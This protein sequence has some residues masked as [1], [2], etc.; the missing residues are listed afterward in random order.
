MCECDWLAGGTELP[1]S[2]LTFV[3]LVA[4]VALGAALRALAALVLV[5]WPA[6]GEA[7][8]GAGH[9]GLP[10]LP[11]PD[12]VPAH[13]ARPHVGGGASA[14]AGLLIVAAH[15]VHLVPQVRAR[16]E[17]TGDG[18]GVHGARGRVGVEGSDGGCGEVSVK[19]HGSGL[20]G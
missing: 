18:P 10:V 12:L 7:A 13:A 14:A 5:A 3:A 8:L 20:A 6:D 16:G 19:R 11:R 9:E 1:T 17:A 4:G 15:D 2:Q